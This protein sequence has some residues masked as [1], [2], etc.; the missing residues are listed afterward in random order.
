MKFCELI[1]RLENSGL[2]FSVICD[3]DT[4][5]GFLT[6]DSRRTTDKTIF[7]CVKGEHAD[8]HD[9]ASQAIAH[10]AKALLCEH[11]L[12]FSVPQIIC[13]D[14]RRNM[15]IVAAA[16]Y[17]HPADKLK[18]VAITGTTGKT[19]S[20]FMTKAVLDYAGMKCGLLGTVCYFDGKEKEQAPR[21]TPEA[22]IIQYKLAQMVKNGCKA[23]VMEASSHSIVQGR[24]EGCKFD[25]AGF[26]NLTQDH[27]DY[28][29]NMENY[30][31]AKKLLFKKYM[32]GNWKL[33]ACCD[34][35]YSARLCKEFAERSIHYSLTDE[36]AEYFARILSVSAQG[37][38]TEFTI[39]KKAAEVLLPIIGSHNIL[40][41]MQALSIAS[42]LG[43]D[44]ATAIDG[45]RQ[46]PQVPGRLER[47]IL[48]NGSYCVIDFAHA[49][50]GLEKLLTALR[51]V[52]KG[53]LILAFG[54]GGD[55]DKSKRPVM[56]E[57]GTRLADYVILTTDNPRSEEAD[58]IIDEIEFGAKRHT[59]EYERIRD[60]REAIY[61]G[62]SMLKA[63]DIFA[64]AGKGPENYMEIKGRKIPF[65]DKQIVLDWCKESGVGV[66]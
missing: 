34:N 1:S 25:T 43:V 52:C 35:E 33:S 58:A 60:R 9:Y 47:L 27:L 31:E 20:T 42:I 32:R 38:K 50:D 22:D 48:E 2:K 37:T 51:E 53:R 55:R 54:A 40:N 65:L 13:E 36:N 62:L 10:G 46:I 24:L 41:A 4:E 39:Y 59:T 3:Y 64:I 21:T 44:T 8:G 23:C 56:G 17:D 5:I 12:D 63:G 29:G 16:L 57:I 11:K 6:A 66:K 19:T 14:I 45:I 61:K 49:P 30:Y 18:M 15:G 26:T 28:H 7:A